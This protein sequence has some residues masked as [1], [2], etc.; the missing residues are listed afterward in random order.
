MEEYKRGPF[1]AT[2]KE[3][4]EDIQDDISMPVSG[5]K[6]KNTIFHIFFKEIYYPSRLIFPALR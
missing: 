6:V 1:N 3:E 4:V 2:I 5:F